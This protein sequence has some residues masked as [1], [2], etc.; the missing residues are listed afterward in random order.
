MS[1]ESIKPLVIRA[2]RGMKAQGVIAYDTHAEQCFLRTDSGLACAVGQVID[3]ANYDPNM[4]LSANPD[5]SGNDFLR[6][7][8]AASNPNLDLDS[9]NDK[10]QAWEALGTLQEIHDTSDNVESFIENSIKQIHEIYGIKID[11]QMEIADV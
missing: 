9:E 6:N 10:D 3:N 2:L 1:Y 11:Y 7:A 8:I 5:L 4:E